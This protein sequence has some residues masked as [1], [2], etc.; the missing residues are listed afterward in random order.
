[1]VARLIAITQDQI[2]QLQPG[3]IMMNDHTLPGSH[4][5]RPIPRYDYPT[6]NCGQQIVGVLRP[7]GKAASRHCQQQVCSSGAPKHRCV[8]ENVF[9]CFTQFSFTSGPLYLQFL[10]GTMP[11]HLVRDIDNV[12]A[13]N[14]VYRG[15]K[16]LMASHFLFLPLLTMFPPP[17]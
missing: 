10:S 2:D 13:S 6:N 15:K 12:S 9:P 7:E 1:M 8:Y 11:Q 17:T 14:L 4:P 5:L 16:L 3:T